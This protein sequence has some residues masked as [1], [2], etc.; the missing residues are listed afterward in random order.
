MQFAE[1][2]TPG[3]TVHRSEEVSGTQVHSSLMGPLLH[4]ISC[5]CHVGVHERLPRVG[6]S[7]VLFPFGGRTIR[8]PFL[9]FKKK[10]QLRDYEQW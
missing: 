2:T 8:E 5:L 10:K 7:E 9:Y 1:S 3:G 4:F 6:G